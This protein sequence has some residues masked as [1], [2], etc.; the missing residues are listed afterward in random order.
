MQPTGLHELRLDAWVDVTRAYWQFAF[1]AYVE[2]TC[3]RC[4]TEPP[5]FSAE[6]QG[7]RTERSLRVSDTPSWATS[8]VCVREAG[9]F[10]LS[11]VAPD[12]LAFHRNVF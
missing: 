11:Q 1:G 9:R 10:V 3:A 2:E 6:G 5:L 12:R 4:T 7:G 8:A